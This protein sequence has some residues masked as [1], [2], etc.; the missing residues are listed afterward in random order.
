MSA[1]PPQMTF[2]QRMQRAADKQNIVL[3]FLR[4]E[5]YTTLN[6]MQMLL[7]L[8]A[9]QTKRTL[10]AMERAELITRQQVTAPSGWRPM[11]WGITPKGQLMAGDDHEIP[12]ASYFKPNR[13]GLTLLSHTVGLQRMKISAERAG[14]AGWESGDRL[15]KFDADSR[16]DATAKDAA[17]TVWCVEFERTIKTSG[18]YESI[19][20]TRLRDIKAG[21]YQRAIW[22]TETPHEAARLRGLVLSIREFSRTHAGVKQ[23]VRIIPEQHHPLLAFTH[24]DAFPAR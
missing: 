24:I 2:A 8:S 15:A 12:S 9:D 1:L 11:L 14:W 10:V 5:I 16:P 4:E 20:F 23:T 18:R 22:V 17:G 21:K 7:G 19:L 13:I 3:R 6:V